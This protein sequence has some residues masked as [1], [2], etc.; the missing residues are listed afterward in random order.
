[1]FK[2]LKRYEHKIHE[3]EVPLTLSKKIIRLKDYQK[4][5]HKTKEE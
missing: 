1:M 5:C 4:N 3:S 2:K